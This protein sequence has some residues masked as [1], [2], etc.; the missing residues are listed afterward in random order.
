[1]KRKLLKAL[2]IVFPIVVVLIAIFF[3]LQ[4]FSL[5]LALTLGGF[6]TEIKYEFA[7]TGTVRYDEHQ[8]FHNTLDE[9][10]HTFTSFYTMTRDGQHALVALEK[11]ALG[12]WK[13]TQTA[14]LTDDQP[15][16][17]IQWV[18][19]GNLGIIDLEKLG[20]D[21]YT[22]NP[23]APMSEDNTVIMGNNALLDIDTTLLKYEHLFPN[24]YYKVYQDGAF[25]IVYEMA[26]QSTHHSVIYQTLQHAGC[27]PSD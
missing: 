14:I 8:F 3:I 15:Y 21:P 23:K 2:N 22:D 25:Y 17:T 26:Q 5:P 7:P 16:V 4:T 6:D 10:G 19:L 24:Y 18:E 27:V 11:N 1:M 20:L 9:G 12:F 13:I